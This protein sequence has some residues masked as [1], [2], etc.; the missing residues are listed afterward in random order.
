M[1][2]SALQNH[3]RLAAAISGVTLWRNNVGVLLDARGIPVRYGLANESKQLNAQFKSA[4]L[5]GWT[6]DGRFVSIE[7]KSR[8][9]RIDPAQERWRS[10]VCE[11]GGIGLVVRSCEELL[12]GLTKNAV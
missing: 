6:A 2:E 4:D 9:G 12:E 10:L 7:V 3:I 8:S 11:R 5:I 1:S